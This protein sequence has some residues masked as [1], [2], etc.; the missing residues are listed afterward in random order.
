MVSYILAAMLS[1]V[2]VG[3]ISQADHILISTDQLVKKVEAQKTLKAEYKYKKVVVYY[4]TYCPACHKLMGK[5]DKLGVKYTKINIQAGDVPGI[6]Y[7]PVMKV[8][9]KTYVGDMSVSALKKA[10]GI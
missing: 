1:F 8:D 4:T 3:N 9:G 7:V 5:L 2:T 10:L 6:D